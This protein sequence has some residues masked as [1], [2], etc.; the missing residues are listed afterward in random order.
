M[1]L[2]V[3]NTRLSNAASQESINYKMVCDVF[4]SACFKAGLPS[5]KKEGKK[6]SQQRTDLGFAEENH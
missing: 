5:L 2:P 4:T 6:K 3:I 1:T